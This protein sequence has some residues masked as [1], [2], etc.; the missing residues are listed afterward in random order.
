VDNTQLGAGQDTVAKGALHVRG[1]LEHVLAVDVRVAED[2]QLRADSTKLLLYLLE[3]REACRV[4]AK[5]ALRAATLS[6]RAL[7]VNV[8]PSSCK[9]MR[10]RLRYGWN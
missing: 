3:A 9:G 4:R 5:A 1:A 6:R 2:V 10:L 8:K 7:R